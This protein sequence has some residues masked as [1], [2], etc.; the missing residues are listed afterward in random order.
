MRRHLQQT[1][2]L[3]DRIAAF[4]RGIRAKA[5][6]LPPSREKEDLLRRARLADMAS[7]LD[8]PDNSPG[9]QKPK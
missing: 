7:H 8:N 3:Q 6:L 2:P 4:A 1:E 9:L 5:S